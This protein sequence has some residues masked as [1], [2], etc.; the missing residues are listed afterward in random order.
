VQ[1]KGGTV[2]QLG[3]VSLELRAANA[4]L[5]YVRY[6][7]KMLWPAD[8][9]AMYPLPR[10]L[11][12]VG[13]LA[14]A[15]LIMISITVLAGLARRQRPYLLVGW[16]WYV[17]TLLPVIGIVQVGA[18]AMADRYTYVPL[19]GLFIMIAWGI[20][21]LLTALPARRRSL[22]LASALVLVACAALSFRQVQYWRTSL[23]LWS[24]AVASAPQNYYA[25][26][27]LGYVLWKGGNIDAA[28]PHYTEA[29]RLR[30][31]FAEGQNNLGVALAGQGRWNE[32]LPHFSE[33]VRLKPDYAV[34]QENLRAA[35]ARHDAPDDSLAQLAGAVRDKSN[36]LV[37]RN[38][39]GAALSSRG[40]IDEAIQQFVEALRIDPAQPDVHYNLGMMLDRKGRTPEAVAE[41]R[42]ALRI[43]P[44]HSPAQHA[45][46]AVLAR[47]ARPAP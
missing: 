20:P 19:V 14:G 46:D 27:S 2:M 25:H 44:K 31:D 30:P 4:V 35:T 10:D 9:I 38:E 22:E 39:Y 34:A 33:A 15:A 16:L 45:L 12:G 7:G 8:L 41:F 17:I 5:A 23:S 3:Q 1:R 28:I 11:P 24:H 26:G 21:D 18:Q 47:M 13:M 36:D 6:V 32:A 29:L 37:A 42:A 43:D 40:R